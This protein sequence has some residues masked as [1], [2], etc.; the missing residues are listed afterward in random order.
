[1]LSNESLCKYSFIYLK[2]NE[3]LSRYKY[4]KPDFTKLSKKDS[5]K[6][7]PIPKEFRTLNS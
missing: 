4:E 1:M 2:Y 7:G 3:S 5:L 6:A